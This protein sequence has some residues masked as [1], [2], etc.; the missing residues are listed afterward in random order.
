[1]PVCHDTWSFLSK[2]PVLSALLASPNFPSEKPSPILL[3]QTE[4]P[5]SMLPQ[6]SVCNVNTALPMFDFSPHPIPRL[7]IIQSRKLVFI[8]A[9]LTRKH[10]YVWYILGS[11]YILSISYV[12]GLILETREWW[13][14]QTRS[15]FSRDIR[16]GGRDRQVITNELQLNYRWAKCWEKGVISLG[17]YPSLVKRFLNRPDDED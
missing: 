10:W 15:L 17:T 3:K 9:S 11:Q 12:Q 4:L 1:M 5:S 7:R 13:T 8:F 6:P 16:S 2:C 14:E